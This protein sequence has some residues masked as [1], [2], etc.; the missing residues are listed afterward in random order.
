M[1][2]DFKKLFIARWKQYVPAVELPITFYYTDENPTGKLVKPTDTHRCMISELLHV[3]A[4]EDLVFDTK[5]FGC[6]GGRRYAGYSDKL[7][8]GF[9]YF[10]SCGI[11]GK[12]E[13]ERYKKTPDSVLKLLEEV[14]PMKAR[15]KY[16]VFKRW[17][18]LEEEDLPLV[19]IFFAAPD[20][21]SALF[22]LANF[23]G[24]SLHNVIAPF[25]AGCASIIEHPLRELDNEIQHAILGMF[26]ISARPHVPKQELSFA[27]P[28]PKFHQMVNNM[29]ESFL[30]T[31]SWETVKKMF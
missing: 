30:I 12:M 21:L 6:A 11:P 23:E 27:I 1:D 19:V 16:L 28:Y 22:T 9:E 18:K 2:K 7:R 25:G 17:D 26:D 5:S 31:E 15:G 3:R 24:E 4:G 13:G 20:I 14:K 8:P 10:L 29:D